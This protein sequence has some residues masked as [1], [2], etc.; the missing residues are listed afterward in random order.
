LTL[1]YWVKKWLITG[2]DVSGYSLLYVRPAQQ[3]IAKAEAARIDKSVIT[4]L[5]G[6]LLYLSCSVVSLIFN[7]LEEKNVIPRRPGR[8]F[9]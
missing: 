1:I 6:I 5:P 4:K 9:D 7:L 3:A 2:C 8:A